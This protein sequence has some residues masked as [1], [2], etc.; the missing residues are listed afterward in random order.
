[1]RVAVT[2]VGPTGKIGAHF[3]LVATVPGSGRQLKHGQGFKLIGVFGP[4]VKKVAAPSLGRD[5]HVLRSLPIGVAVES[6]VPNDGAENGS[7]AEL[8]AVSDT[9]GNTF[10]TIVRGRALW[11][12]GIDVRK[13]RSHRK[14]VHVRGQ[15]VSGGQNRLE[16][17]KR[18]ETLGL[19]FIVRPGQPAHRPG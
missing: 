4:G 14:D 1:M 2:G 11:H 5:K 17:G 9:D 16:A 15:Q 18:I 10:L 6:G 12:Q 19:D 8:V 7:R 13:L 3:Q